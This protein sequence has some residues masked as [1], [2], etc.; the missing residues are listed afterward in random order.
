MLVNK[1]SRMDKLESSRLVETVICNHL[2]VDSFY[3]EP[4]DECKFDYLEIRDGANG[5]DPLVG[6]YCGRSFPPIIIS[7]G[8]ALWLRFH[9]DENA[10][11]S[12]F[13]AVYEEVKKP[14]VLVMF[15]C[16]NCG[17]Q[18]VCI[19][20]WRLLSVPEVLCIHIKLFT[21]VDGSLFKGADKIQFPLEGLDMRYYM[22]N[23]VADSYD[24]T[25]RYTLI[26]VI[27]HKETNETSGHFTCYCLNYSNNQWYHYDDEQVTRVNSE[28]VKK[29]QAYILFYRKEGTIKRRIMDKI[30][31]LRNLSKYEPKNFLI[32]KKWLIR[33]NSFS[34]PGAVANDA[35]F[36]EH[37][38][39]KNSAEYVEITYPVWAYVQRIF[40]GGPAIMV[41]DLCE[42]CFEYE[43]SEIQARVRREFN[44]EE[45]ED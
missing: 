20:R 10:E 22:K 33:Y 27:C 41:E 11:Y 26:S 15:S 40:G 3:I 19:K 7:T 29:V 24:Y 16:S 18:S 12:G 38:K 42:F 1:L 14:G 34:K 43:L 17:K 23:D 4:S 45:V 21:N 8:R 30:S 2:D 39:V 5:Y 13:R 6:S 44:I 37:G 28:V 32:S 35:K 36:C 9:S 25:T 31:L